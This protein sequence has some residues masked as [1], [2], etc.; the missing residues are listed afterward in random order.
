MT[1]ARS[2]DFR[3]LKA[4]VTVERVLEARGLLAS[5]R[6]RGNNLV[7][8]CPIHGGDAPNG[9]VVSRAKNL[10]YCFTRCRAG[11]DVVDLVCLLDRSSYRETALY[12]ASL[13]GATA[14]RPAPPPP[15]F[16]PFTARLDLNPRAPFLASKGICPATARAF[17][18]GLFRGSGFLEGCVAVRLHDPRGQ[19]LGYAGRIL[20]PDRARHGKWKLPA[21][22][23]KRSLLFNYHRAHGHP[24]RGLVVVEDPWSVMRLAQLRIPAVALLG[25]ALSSEQAALLAPC[26]R[27]L[28]MLDGDAAGRLAAR[29]LLARLAPTQVGVA[30]LPDRLDPDQLDDHDLEAICR[31]FLPALAH[32]KA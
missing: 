24:H 23:P 6:L 16:R 31:L 2:L 32:H 28:L 11:G 3:F 19:P 4:H 15:A 18:C 22:L 17:D 5:L 8:P 14:H 13:A 25:T 1:P 20:D 29:D 7:G 26:S 30:E 21:R 10:W 12:L 27:I 9:F